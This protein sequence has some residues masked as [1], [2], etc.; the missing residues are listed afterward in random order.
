MAHLFSDIG[1]RFVNLHCQGLAC[2]TCNDVLMIP[3][4][5]INAATGVL[6]QRNGFDVLSLVILHKLGYVQTP[7]SNAVTRTSKTAA[8]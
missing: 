7:N 6:P 3:L 4:G 2:S 1:K 5:K 8:M